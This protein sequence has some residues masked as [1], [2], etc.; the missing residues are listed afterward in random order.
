MACLLPSLFVLFFCTSAVSQAVSVSPSDVNAYSQG[1]T[2]V[3]LTFGG[4]ANKRAAEATWCGA[5]I[6]ASSDLGF[7]CDNATIFGRKAPPI[8]RMRT[9]SHEG[10]ALQKFVACRNTP[11]TSLSKSSRLESCFLR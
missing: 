8:C 5:L 3:L 4:L 11:S 7:K 6:P 1:A 2:S 9:F 10:G